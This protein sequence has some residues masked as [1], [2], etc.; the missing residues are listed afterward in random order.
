MALQTGA[1]ADGVLIVL[2]G[3]TGPEYAGDPLVKCPCCDFTGHLIADFSY[4]IAGLN[5]I[6]PHSAD[7]CG[8][9]ECPN[10]HRLEW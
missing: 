4:L 5:G 2:E 7:D 8:L 3:S 10:G 1:K 6:E 9:Q